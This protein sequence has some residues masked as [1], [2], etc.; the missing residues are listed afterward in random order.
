MHP[1]LAPSSEYEQKV[2]APAADQE[3][4]TELLRSYLKIYDGYHNQ[5]ETVA[6]A[7]TVFYL[8]GASALIGLEN[9]FWNESTGAKLLAAGLT[10]F[11]IILSLAFVLWQFRLRRAA[12]DIYKACNIV[13]T[14]WVSSPPTTADLKSLTFAEGMPLLS[15]F[16]WPQAL[17]T[18]VSNICQ[19][20]RG[21][22]TPRDLAWMAMVSWTAA[23]LWRIAGR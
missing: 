18:Q 16:K 5:K 10:V 6:L 7:F 2:P 19:E 3:K 11:A 17:H 20:R 8:G 14:D 21:W 22:W 12:G 1:E 15:G 23:V 13:L 4:A 9:P